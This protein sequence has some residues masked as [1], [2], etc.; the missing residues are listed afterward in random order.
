[1]ADVIF[2]A[3]CLFPSEKRM[4]KKKK[5]RKFAFFV[6]FLK[7]DQIL[8]NT[9]TFKIRFVFQ[10]NTQTSPQHPFKHILKTFGV[11]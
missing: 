4:V 10:R 7:N 1:M 9:K 3:V 2:V 8:T 6:F 11:K 5:Q